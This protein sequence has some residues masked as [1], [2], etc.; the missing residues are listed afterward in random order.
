[1]RDLHN[2]INPSKITIVTVNDNTPIVSEIVYMPPYN[3][4]EFIIA[5]GNL[6]SAT[7]TFTVKI[8]DGNVANL[9]DATIV[10]DT[11]LLGTVALAGFTFANDY[12]PRKIGYMG[13]KT[14]VRCTITPASN[15][16][17]ATVAIIPILTDGGTYPTNNPPK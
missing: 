6:V 4:L 16:S 10:A 15:A 8:E 2:R 17:A 5:P 3:A 7:A 12:A 1:M 14:Y 11:F 13:R 9:S